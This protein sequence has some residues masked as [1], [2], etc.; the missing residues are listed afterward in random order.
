MRLCAILLKS[1]QESNPFRM[2]FRRW[3]SVVLVL[4]IV[5]GLAVFLYRQW[6]GPVVPG[7]GM[8]LHP[9]V[10]K[11]VATGRVVAASR[12]QVG[13]EITGVVVERRVREGDRV[14]PG[15]VLV[16]LRSE[17]LEARVRE[18][19]AALDQL[20]RS[21]RPQA[22]AALREANVRVAQARREAQRREELLRARAVS[23]EVK[24]QADQMLATAIATAQRAQLEAD[25]LAPGQSEERMLRERLAIAEAALARTVITSEVAGTVLTR[26]VEPG[27]QVQPGRVLLEI[28]RS[29]DTELLVPV[30][31]KNLA[32]LQVGQGAQVVADAYPARPF[33][34][35]VVFIAPA[36]DPQRG[37]V[38]VRLQADP[39]PEFLL[40]DMTV[41]VNILTA[42]RDQALVVPND[43]LRSLVGDT[44]FVWRVSNGRVER[45]DVVLGL[46]GLALSEVTSGLEVGDWVL[47]GGPYAAGQRVRVAPEP[48]PAAESQ[49]LQTGAASPG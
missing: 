26:A 7:Y 49:R 27:D 29:G 43:A 17:E 24:E 9:L 34:A 46:R 13:S 48:L 11:V 40:E 21:R 42:R 39:V 28:A 35:T 37:T 15:D 14:E 4:L 47:P 8:A 45:A 32:T 33:D 12:V 6:Q 36:I 5:L 41:S 30:D 18:A 2:R 1:F 19:R 20:A 16:M 23:R 22:L 44:A 10:Q 25:A 38:D 31:E 3:S